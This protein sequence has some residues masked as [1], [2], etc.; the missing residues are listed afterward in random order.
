MGNDAQTGADVRTCQTEIEMI[1]ITVAVS[2]ISVARS[3]LKQNEDFPL[4]DMGCRSGTGRSKDLHF[5]Q[6]GVRQETGQIM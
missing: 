4:P 5:P 2:V 3:P 6:S 1:P